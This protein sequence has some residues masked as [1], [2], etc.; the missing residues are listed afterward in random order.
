MTAGAIAASDVVVV[1]GGIV[2]AASA[3]HLARDGL[4]VTLCEKEDLA[5]GASG[6][7]PGFV[8]MHTRR[9]GTQLALARMSRRMYEHLEAELDWPFDFRANGGLIFFHTPEQRKVMEEFVAERQ[10]LGVDVVLLDGDEAR[11]AAPVLPEDVIGASF[12]REDAQITAAKLVEGFGRAAEREGAVVLRRTEVREVLLKKGRVTGI[13]TSAGTI[14]TGAVVLAAGVWTPFLTARLGVDLPIRPMRLQVVSTDVQPPML[15]RLLYGPRAIR[16]YEVFRGLPSYD[17]SA[18]AETGDDVEGEL[19]FLELA[20]QTTAGRFLLGCPM[21]M[22]GHVWE[23]DLAGVGLIC[24]SLPEAIP[25]LRSAR[26]ERAWAGLLPHTAD[27]LPVVDAVPDFPGLFVAAGHVFGNSAGPAT[28][29]LVSELVRGEPPSLDLDELRF[30]RAGL[31]I[32][33]GEDTGW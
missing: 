21:D 16:Q 13:E 11:A 28:G 10:V 6:R 31:R 22:P 7:N 27:S 30:G 24:R 29:R 14:D 23:P 33:T 25:A 12:C 1:G 18:F 26:F 9:A 20:C 19:P 17:A 4:S 15:D 32:A 3:Y 8:W 5:F 2:G